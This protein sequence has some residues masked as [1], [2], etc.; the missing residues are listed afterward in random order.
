MCCRDLDDNNFGGTLDLA[1]ILN[2][3]HAGATSELTL[4]ITNNNISGVIYNDYVSNLR[5]LIV[6]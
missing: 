4:S 3:R 1:Q 2:T 6:K 5:T